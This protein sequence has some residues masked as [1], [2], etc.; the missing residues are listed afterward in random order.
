MI[1]FERFSA[2]I[3]ALFWFYEGRD[4]C[5][6]CGFPGLATHEGHVVAIKPRPVYHGYTSTYVEPYLEIAR[7]P[8]PENVL[9]EVIESIRDL[10]ITLEAVFKI[11]AHGPGETLT[12]EQ[13]KKKFNSGYCCITMHGLLDAVK[14][15]LEDKESRQV[16][17]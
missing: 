12:S 16:S 11:V 9:D 5:I 7:R 8:I 15:T 3:N 14:K 1:T 17:A 4:F 6:A 2:R 10:E 13:I